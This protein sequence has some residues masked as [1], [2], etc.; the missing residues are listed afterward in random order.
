MNKNFTISQWS[1]GQE[2]GAQGPA[3]SSLIFP[4][5]NTARLLFLSATG[6]KRTSVG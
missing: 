4:K 2:I 6:P 1:Q 5:E 3:R